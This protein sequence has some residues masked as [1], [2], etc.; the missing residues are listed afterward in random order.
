LEKEVDMLKSKK[1]LEII[2]YVPFDNDYEDNPCDFAKSRIVAFANRKIYA[3]ST[4]MEI[5]KNGK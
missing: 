1:G 4:P 5:E 3:M 2:T